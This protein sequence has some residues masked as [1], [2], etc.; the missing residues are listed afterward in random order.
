MVTPVRGVRVLLLTQYYAPETGAPQTR[1]AETVAGLQARGFHVTVVAPIPSYPQGR[2]AAGYRWWRPARE[3]IWGAPVRRLPALVVPG[4]RMSR[5][6][7]NHAT[8][9]VT[10]L[11]SLALGS[12]A[13][14]ALVESPPLFLALPARALS[15]AGVPY[16]FHVADPWPDF[17]IAMGYLQA[18]WQRRLAYG[19]EDFAYRGAAAITTVSPGLVEL[20]AR[21]PAARGRV[22]LIPNGVD[23][24]RFTDVPDP[25]QARRRL[26]WDEAFT[27]VYVGTVGL[28]QGVGT[29]LDAA[30][31]LG[32]GVRFHVVG[33]GAEK[34]ALEAR[35]RA[36]HL[37][38]VRFHAAV[39]AES[40]PDVLAAADAVLV[41]LRRGPL[42]E[43]SLPTKL[44]EAMAA[45]RPVVVSADG[46]AMRI[47]AEARCGFAACAEDARDLA[48]AVE[49]CRAHPDRPSL[50]MAARAHVA[51]HFERGRIL[52]GL[53]DV[54]ARASRTRRGGMGA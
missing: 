13:D 35:A 34:P 40:V 6:L 5:R 37:S 4:A 54:I 28:A 45:S 36:L 53:A 14:V 38:S 11:S 19:L 44:L 2:V 3:T 41:L 9:A 43:E 42:F 47:V 21:K 50:G 10:S 30:A 7:A 1:L 48:A 12:R 22:H 16:V 26:G 31:F 27:I 52:D 51:Q 39:P 18:P 25:G 24:A 8:F 17:P 20:L 23:L 29:L 32:E 33:E 15:A 49:R 46:L